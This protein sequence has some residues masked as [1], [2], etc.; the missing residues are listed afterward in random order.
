MQPLREVAISV[1]NFGLGNVYHV[2]PT[3]QVERQE[4]QIEGSHDGVEWRS[5]VFRYKPG[6]LNKRPEFIVP[7][8]PRLDWMIWFVP[9]QRSDQL[10]WLDRM[11]QRLEE[12]S[13]QVTGLLA[14]NPFADR[15]PRF[16]RVLAF[17]YRFTTAR[18]H[19]E[20]GNWWRRDF[21]G[22]F[23][24]VPPRRP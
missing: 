10:Y 16:L 8:Q 3:M 17:S 6:A 23:P 20:T 1:R 24:Y 22:E 19:A 5:Y 4:L 15:P 18:Q 14:G 7:Y 21:V 13:P 12:N 9:S 2:F 11:L